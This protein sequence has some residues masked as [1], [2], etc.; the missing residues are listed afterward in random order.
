MQKTL[1]RALVERMDSKN[2]LDMAKS[3]SPLGDMG[4]GPVDV[5]AVFPNPGKFS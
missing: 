4:D 2:S 3:R 5:M 1:R